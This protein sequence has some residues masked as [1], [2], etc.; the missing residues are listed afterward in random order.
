MAEQLGACFRQADQPG[1]SSSP[2]TKSRD[3]F[4]DLTSN[5]FDIVGIC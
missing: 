1:L 2:Y 3:R 4:E 5:V